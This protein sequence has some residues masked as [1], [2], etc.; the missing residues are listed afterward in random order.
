[1]PMTIMDDNYLKKKLNRVKA[2]IDK[3][4]AELE[5]AP[6]Q[7]AME[8]TRELTNCE[9]T[10]RSLEQRLDRYKPSVGEEYR[11]MN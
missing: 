4:Q 8:I 7:R 2:Q 9:C 10:K 3:L 1:M 5:K 6:L 11:I